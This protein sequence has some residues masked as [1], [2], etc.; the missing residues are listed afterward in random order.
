MLLASI[1]FEEL[2]LA[3]M[4]NAEAEKLQEVIT[5]YQSIRQL[6]KINDKVREVIKVLLFKEIVLSMKLQDVLRLIKEEKRNVGH[7]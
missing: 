1:A 7:T 3:H 2:A 6:V 4:L 5:S